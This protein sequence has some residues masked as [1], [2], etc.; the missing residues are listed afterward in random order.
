M[1]PQ[2]PPRNRIRFRVRTPSYWISGHVFSSHRRLVDLLNSMDARGFLVAE[3]VTIRASLESSAVGETA[4]RALVYSSSILFAI[5]LEEAPLHRDPH[6]WVSKRPEPV[7]AGIGP[8]RLVGSIHLVRESQLADALQAIPRF[9][10]LAPAL[11]RHSTDLSLHE[12]H[13]VVLLN[14]DHLDYVAPGPAW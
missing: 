2:G 4:E 11:I 13:E 5:P 9:V 10:P 3:E 12:E 6:N 8:Y 7:R 1:I 14:R